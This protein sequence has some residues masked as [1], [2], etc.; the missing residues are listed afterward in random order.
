MAEPTHPDPRPRRRRR[1]GAGGRR[2]RRPPRLPADPDQLVRPPLHRDLHRRGAH[3]PL[4]ALPRA[5]RSRSGSATSWS[6]RS[7]SRHPQGLTPKETPM[8]ALVLEEKH[9]LS[10]RDFPIEK[11]GDAR[12]PRRAHQAPH[13]RHLRLRRAL[14]HPRRHRPLRRQRADDPRPRGLRHRHRG[15]PRGHDP[16]ARRPR[17]HG[18]GH[19]RPR[20]PRHPPRHLQRRPGRALLGDAARPR[21]PP[22]DRRPPRALHLQAPRQRQLR[23]SRDGRAPRR[24]RPRRHQGAR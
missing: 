2:P 16:E 14:L 19:P 10:L 15:R 22:P 24:R 20:Q 12:P 6:S 13:R 11:R 17:L 9:K 3:P 8:K 7:A 21:H 5:D 1:G 4:D 23:R 18:A